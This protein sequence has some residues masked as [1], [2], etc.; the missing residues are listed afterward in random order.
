MRHATV[1]ISAIVKIRLIGSAE[2]KNF[3]PSFSLH[4]EIPFRFISASLVH[5]VFSAS[6]HQMPSY[7]RQNR[8]KF[9]FRALMF[10]TFLCSHQ[11]F[12]DAPDMYSSGIWCSQIVNEKHEMY[13]ETAHRMAQMVLG[14]ATFPAVHYT[15][16]HLRQISN[17]LSLFG[18][19]DRRFFFLFSWH[20]S[21]GGGE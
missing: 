15:V 6:L 8:N 11:P 16:A 12:C 19:N 7:A 9:Q 21:Q 1:V 18:S 10:L 4:R 14:Y 20:C 2:C 3:P 13:F 5:F 17:R